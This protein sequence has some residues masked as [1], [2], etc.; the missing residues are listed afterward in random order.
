MTPDAEALLLVIAGAILLI[1]L[2]SGRIVRLSVTEPL[3]AVSAGVLIAVLLDGHID[4]ADFGARSFLEVTL[5][6]V[7]FSDAGRIDLSRLRDEY[8]WPARMLAIGLPLAMVGGAALGAWLFSLPVGAALLIGVILAPTDAALAE[9]VLHDPSLPPRIRQ[10]LN[11]EAGLNDGLALPALFIAI[12]VFE[13]GGAGGFGSGLLLTVQQ[14]G[15]G[16]VGGVVFGASGAWA[17]GRAIEAGWMDHL[18]QK[19]A[20][21]ALALAAFALV[22]L[23]G[24]S[25][26]VAAFVAG[27]VL[28]TRF[29]PRGEHI[30]EFAETEGRALVLIAFIL[31]GA[32][33]VYALFGADL[34]WQ[35]WAMAGAS[36]LVVRPLAIAVSLVGEKL[37]G[38]TV[39]F[40]GWFGPR[41][42]ATAVFLLVA[43]DEG[44]GV[45]AVVSQVAYLTLA[46]S[47]LLHGLTA[48]PLSAWCAAAIGRGG[49]DM[50]EMGEAY[51]HP[52]M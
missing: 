33:P 21:V 32:G 20:A 29:R 46:L 8:S 28:G 7:L 12:G 14:L 2:V 45:P 39:V 44:A 22:Q 26:F 40:L 37:M 41:G 4:L 6:L 16:A 48:K 35:V 13:M 3:L 9:P 50:P 30:Y 10:S 27:G 43:L 42:L 15:I 23:L 1:V 34:S 36:L 25:G 49:A 47:V 19:I 24:G 51:E 18:H 17:I 5:A 38:T 31:I 11:V 52:I